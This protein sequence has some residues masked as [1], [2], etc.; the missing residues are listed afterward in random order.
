[1]FESSNRVSHRHKP[2]WIVPLIGA[3]V[4]LLVAG[5]DAASTPAT[6]QGPLNV[7]L[8]YFP[9]L[10]HAP[11]LVGIDKGYFQRALGPTT[12]LTTE[13]FKAGPAEIEALFGGAIDIGFIGPG[14]AVNA[15]VKSHGD[16]LRIVAGA[17][18]GGASLVVRPG[19]RIGTPAELRGKTLATPQ[20][21]NTQDVALRAYLLA[22]GL[23][24]DPQGGGDTRV[25]PTA[26]ET[27]L[28]LF[29]DGKIDG[30]WVPEPW[31]SRLEKDAAGKVLVDER[32]LWPDGQFASTEVIVARTF[33]ERHPDTVK[34]FLT[35]EV[36]AIDWID[37]NPVEAKAAV[38]DS[39]SARTPTPL[40]AS[41]LDLAWSRLAFTVDPLAATLRKESGDAVKVG[42][43]KSAN[44]NGIVDL[45][46]VNQVLSAKGLQRLSAAG[47][48]NE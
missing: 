38:N 2:G 3:V 31:A 47:L 27:T 19:A 7:R 9:N 36:S 11:A 30:A 18:A 25:V 14:P 48:G 23:K 45:R 16:A 42:I 24:T 43:V 15:Y 10:T 1:M 22:I 35:G 39:L 44:I 29:R 4:A 17:A 5:C 13:T 21:G 20:L 6:S 46:L 32:T 33:V 40:K 12:H 28:Q 8:G 41:V 26:N 37:K 34:A